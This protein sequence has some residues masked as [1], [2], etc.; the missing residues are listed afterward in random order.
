MRKS[1]LVTMRIHPGEKGLFVFGHGANRSETWSAGFM[2][3]A[4]SCFSMLRSG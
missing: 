1:A 2:G 4:W 3:F